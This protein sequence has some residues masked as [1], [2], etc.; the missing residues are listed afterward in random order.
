M[1]LEGN[2]HSVPMLLFNDH[3]DSFTDVEKCYLPEEMKY[4][5]VL[6]ASY[7]VPASLV[8]VFKH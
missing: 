6:E 2:I 1:H 3:Q 8:H 7:Q 5:P 4:K